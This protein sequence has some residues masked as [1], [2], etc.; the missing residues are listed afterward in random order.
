MSKKIKAL[1][2]PWPAITVFT[3]ALAS[4]SGTTPTPTLSSVADS[5]TDQTSSQ[6]AS[7]A[8]EA[9]KSEGNK[10][11][12]D[13]Y[14]LYRKDA[15]SEGKTP[16]SYEEWLK[17]IK[18]EPGDTP[19][20]GDNGDW[21]I[22]NTDTGVSAAGE[23]GE[24]GDKGDT[25]ASVLTGR[26]EPTSGLGQV[27]DSY[28][29]LN[30]F[31]YY[32]KTASGWILQ[33]NLKGPQ[34]EKGDSGEEGSQ[35][36]QGDKGDDGKSAYE[37]YCE[38]HPDYQGNEEQWM[39]DLVNGR[40]ADKPIYTVT[41]D[42]CGGS[43]VPSQ[44]VEDGKKADRPENPEKAGYEFIDWVDENGDH[45]VFNGYCI[46]ED[47]TLY[48]TWSNPIEYTV[49]FINND[50]SVLY[51]TTGH[52]G[53]E[54]EY[55]YDLPTY[56]NP[57][58][59]YDYTFTGWDKDLVVTGDM[60]FYAQYSLLPAV[61]Q[62]RFVNDDGSLLY[63]TSGI[64]GQPIQ[65]LGE[66]PFP[67]NPES[68]YI[69]TFNG[70]DKQLT[71]TGNMTI[72]A[73]Y[74]KTPAHTYTFINPDGSIA[75]QETV[76]EGATPSYMSS[77]PTY[78]GVVEKDSDGISF[79]YFFAGWKVET[80]LDRATVLRAQFEKSTKGLIF[81]LSG[82]TYYVSG[83]NGSST[84]V[85]VPS[86]YNGKAVVAVGPSAFSGNA[87]IVSIKL[88][89]SVTEIKKSAFSGCTSLVDVRL[90]GW[91]YASYAAPEFN[92]DDGK[93]GWQFRFTSMYDSN[94]SVT[95]NITSSGYLALNAVETVDR[96]DLW[97][98]IVTTKVFV[99]GIEHKNAL[100]VG[101]LMV[102]KGDKVQIVCGIGGQLGITTLRVGVSSKEEFRETEADSVAI[103]R[104][105]FNGCS[106]LTSVVI[107]D[108]VASIS[109]SAFS[110]CSSIESITLPFVGGSRTEN[111]FLGYI[112]GASS[113]S[114]NSS[115]V[116]E[117]LKTVILSD[118][119]ESIGRDAFAYC[120]SLV[121]ITIPDSVASIGG[122]AFYNCSSLK[123]VHFIIS[124]MERFVIMTGKDRLP[125]VDVHLI[126]AATGEE[127]TD[128]VIPDSV[129]SILDYA[130]YHCSSLTSVTIGNSVASI[131]ER[132]FYNCS[133]L[134]SV[135]IGNSVASIGERAF[136]NCS[137]LASI[138]FAG[139][140]A[141][142]EAIKLG[143]SWNMDV[144][145]TVVHC[146]DGDITL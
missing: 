94:K 39:D 84:E 79:D 63:Q 110:G 62:I 2:K 120:S 133:T 111:T 55:P 29:D 132:A 91:Q 74:I 61:Y 106:S 105:A 50:G 6:G 123:D 127:I 129:T 100:L 41:F 134:T 76:P 144:S 64:Y 89:D 71:I 135:T 143:Q 130:F 37:I 67:V 17:S 35:G 51:E 82:E 24:K 118:A 43:E 15:L 5:V 119:C 28:I 86:G 52:Y 22:G 57:R 78:S 10:D 21:W 114:K 88:P 145:A 9:S 58:E 42:T 137:S 109:Y 49:T 80:E 128:V 36:E 27:G 125:W 83:Y 72:T 4:C 47:I 69:Y 73:Q 90:P 54:V 1:R 20:I 98:N 53:D 59:H 70:W 139:T 85:V 48:A 13:I 45:W 46:T 122:G 124:S 33:G 103:G 12:Y 7:E 136:Y 141:Q 18:G 95:L 101:G 68:G 97:H 116:P 16:L 65:Y 115:Y 117:N 40:L 107:P 142:W 34:G 131:G 19:Y 25:G 75:Y 112:F 32:T 99:N 146:S 121:S 77:I 92:R 104:E 3:V 126:D 60:V 87:N 96:E 138:T 8:S 81:S 140:K 93:D 113:Q 66:T 26:G 56:V 44:R 14:L 23:K 11:I 108:S 31:D 38:S 102:C 30:T